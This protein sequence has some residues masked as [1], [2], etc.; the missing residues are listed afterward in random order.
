MNNLKL[1]T[2]TL[3]AVLICFGLVLFS[4]CE[5]KAIDYNET[6]KIRPCDN[7]ICLNGG[8]CSDGYCQCPEGYEGVKCETRW[9]EKFVGNFIASDECYTGSTGYYEMTINQD[10]V[11]ANKLLFYKLGVTCTDS[12]IYATI[13]PEKTSFLVPMQNTCGHYYISGYGNM[14]T[15]NNFINVYLKSKDSLNHISMDC[16]IILNRKP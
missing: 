2:G 10:P 12:V 9:T 6:T 3:A 5:K 8:S 13:N 1:I 15:N 7:V 14:N 16:S 11:V 4:S